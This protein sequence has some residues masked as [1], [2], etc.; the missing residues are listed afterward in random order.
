V[1]VFAAIQIFTSELLHASTDVQKSKRA[2][3]S[4]TEG[5]ARGGF[6][7]VLGHWTTTLFSLIGQFHDQVDFCWPTIFVPTKASRNPPRG[8]VIDYREGTNWVDWWSL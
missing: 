8:S 7:A 1:V 5:R 4:Q 6:L 3:S 2:G